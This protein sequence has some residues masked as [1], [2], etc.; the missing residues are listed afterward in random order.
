MPENNQ[1]LSALIRVLF[2][3][4]NTLHLGWPF[5]K[6]LILT[7]ILLSLLLG[8][9]E[10]LTRTRLFKSHFIADARGTPHN[11]FELQLGQLETIVAR[12]GPIECIFL[13]NSMVWRGFDTEAFAQAYKQQTGQDLRCFNFGVDALPA[14]GAGAIA[15][16]LVQDY[17][18]KLLIYG[19]DARDYAV[20]RES[21]DA[22]VLLD[23]PWLR[24]RLGQFS[25]KG[26]LYEHSHFYRYQ[27][28]L[29]HLMRLEK[30]Y[31]L[32]R[33]ADALNKSNY[34][35]HGGGTVGSF[36]S[37][38]PNPNDHTAHVR[39]YFSVL[40]DYK[41]LLEN[42]NGLKQ[43]VRHNT[44]GTQVLVVEMPVPEMYFHFFGKGEQDHQAFLDQIGGIAEANGAPFWHTTALHLIPDD[45][46]GDYSHLN[47]KGATIFSQWFGE[48]LGQAANARLIA[49]L[50]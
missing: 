39:Y 50:K 37:T 16:I 1:R 43:I 19:T 12:E 6:T 3:G 8:A 45:G 15:E 42:L 21:S 44:Q 23:T 9:G 2:S 4:E 11:Q 30:R 22:A 13:G 17:R 46:W 40:S 38:P 34:G 20:K 5:G 14:V 49:G 25:V 28:T 24:Y 41:M 26:W 29:G 7:L 48:Q 47:T 27:R 36:V 32:V 35:F 33:G 10:A 18:P 31:L